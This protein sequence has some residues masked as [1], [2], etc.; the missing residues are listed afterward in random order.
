MREIK[1]DELKLIQLD[2]LKAIDQFCT[3]R[4][5]RYFLAYGTLI[6]AARHKGYI[7]WDD[8]I[9]IVMPR[10]D[11]IEFMNGFNYWGKNHYKVVCNEFDSRYYHP[12]IKVIN[13][14]TVMKEENTNDYEIGVFIDVFP[15]DELP[16]NEND[17]NKLY[18]K[19]RI[20]RDILTLKSIPI[21]ERRSWYKNF[22]LLVGQIVFR[23]IS[24]SYLINKIN[25]LAQTYAGKTANEKI[26]NLT[27]L[28]YGMREIWDAKWFADTVY[29]P[30][31][32]Y[33]FSC[34]QKYTEVLNHTYRD[35]TKLP[36]L[37]KQISTHR[38]YAYWK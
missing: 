17:I 23:P 28:A 29:L 11:Y 25:T 10:K 24:V 35:Y 9:D 15:L 19:I 26:G 31:E 3:E 30:F 4:G 8:D 2:M 21:V 32:G 6:G 27:S 36:P 14:D 37:E 22:I 1:K 7:P 18:K 20:Y 12:F 33:E 38:F 13:I 34:P 16:N 5:I